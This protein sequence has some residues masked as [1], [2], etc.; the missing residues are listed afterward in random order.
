M[1][2]ER[3]T[4]TTHHEPFFHPGV[5][6]EEQRQTTSEYKQ[7]VAAAATEAAEREMAYVRALNPPRVP[8]LEPPQLRQPVLPDGFD[9]AAIDEA[10]FERGVAIDRDRILSLGRERFA[11]LLTLDRTA[12]G[13]QRLVGSATD[14]TSWQSVEFAFAQAG[15][16]ATRV[17]KRTMAEQM[18]GA[19]LDREV[20]A[21][22]NGFD[23]LFKVIADRQPVRDVLAFHDAFVRLVFGQSMAEQLSSDGRIRSRF[24]C[25]GKL[26]TFFSF[27]DWLS[28]L[29][30]PHFKVS[31]VDPLGPLLFWLAGEHTPLPLPAE[32]AREVY[33]NVRSLSPE[34]VRVAR[35]VLD[36]FLLDHRGWA[37]W[38]YV[39]RATRTALDEGLLDTWRKEL[40]KRFRAIAEFHEVLRHSFNKP[41]TRFGESY[42]QFDAVAHRAFIDGMVAQLLQTVSLL[43]AQAVEQSHAV[44][45]RFSDSLLVEGE[46]RQTAALVER[47]A[48]KLNAAFT[49]ANFN[50][51]IEEVE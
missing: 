26:K 30:G 44:V 50:V 46:P 51:T 15:S 8:Q 34:Q 2:H 39:G 12:R 7:N 22:I 6:L 18:S 13:A 48:G 33:N 28:T 37:L 3:P 27:N 4:V 16:L 45:A 23:D 1:P 17:P 49:G 5:A 25:S 10:I 24:F 29:H 20:A 14:L 42:F 11:E 47:V 21:R 38:D 43:A 35:A 36:G 19:G 41:V 32:L 40:S 9:A 31:P